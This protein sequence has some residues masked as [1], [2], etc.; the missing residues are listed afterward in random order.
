MALV[1]SRIVVVAIGVVVLTTGPV[2]E[3]YLLR[4]HEIAHTPGRPYLDLPLEYP[5]LLYAVIRLVGS[6]SALATGL[7]VLML[8]L[9]LDL[10]IAAA[11]WR[12]WGA[13]AAYAYLLLGTPLL[14][15]LYLGLDLVPVALA[16][17][18]LALVLRGRAQAGGATFAAAAFAK[19]WPVVLIPG[20]RRDRRTFAS[21]V[22]VLLLGAVLWLAWSGLEGFQQVATQRGTP[23]WE[24]ESTVGALVW[25]VADAPVGIV[26]DSPRVGTAPIW[27]KLLLAFIAVWW[28]VAIWTRV[29]T[30][31]SE[32]WGQGALAAVAALLA[33]SPILSYPFVAWLLPWGA[34]AAADRDPIPYRI[35]LATT[36]LTGAVHAT[37][38]LGL[39]ITAP[40]LVQAG[41]IARNALL[42]LLG[43]LPFLRHPEPREDLDRASRERA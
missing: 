2:R 14:A 22:L 30:S 8:S 39:P 33:C 26:L 9:C 43:L 40:A 42:I 5:P 28:I 20:L 35:A 16:V 19:V 21:A 29:R 12:D 38:G 13:H 32:A 25:A 17:L 7:A 37:Y 24:V 36:L 41:L 11:L 1:G 3:G 10:G 31:P 15:F 18:G 27:A 23:G 6:G 4:F 34:I